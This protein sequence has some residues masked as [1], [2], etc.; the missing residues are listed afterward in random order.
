MLRDPEY[1][2]LGDA[3]GDLAE[4]LYR[5]GRYDEADLAA[6]EAIQQGSPSAG[7][8]ILGN[9]AYDLLHLEE[10]SNTTPGPAR[11]PPKAAATGSQPSK[12]WWIP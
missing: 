2:H 5:L 12:W 9:L 1:G 11:R 8:L 10:A 7:Y 3:Y 4:V 6:R